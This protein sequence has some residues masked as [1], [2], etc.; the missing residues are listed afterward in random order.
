MEHEIFYFELFGFCKTLVKVTKIFLKFILPWQKSE[1]ICQI[2]YICIL[3][4]LNHLRDVNLHMNALNNIKSEWTKVM[5]KYMT[6]YYTNM[7]LS[8]S[9]LGTTLFAF[10][11]QAFV[12]RSKSATKWAFV[13]FSR[14]EFLG[15]SPKVSIKKIFLVML[16][17]E[18]Q[19]KSDHNY[20]C[21]YWVF[22]DTFEMPLNQKYLIRFFFFSLSIR[23]SLLGKQK[24]EHTFF[25]YYTN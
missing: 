20:Y 1:K 12:V 15:G 9:L 19:L 24:Q 7:N 11:V 3:R 17:T 18:I 13:S 22:E 5:V 6:F 21:Y 25:I 8:S 16:L 2:C 14:R 23:F 4:N 10:N